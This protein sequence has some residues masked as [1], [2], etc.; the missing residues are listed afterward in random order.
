MNSRI[1]TNREADMKTGKKY[2]KTRSGKFPQREDVGQ[3]LKSPA[4]GSFW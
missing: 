3:N 1:L 2:E 4:A